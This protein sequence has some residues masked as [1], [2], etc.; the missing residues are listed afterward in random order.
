MCV[1]PALRRRVAAL[2]G[3]HGQF[4]ELEEEMHE[5]L[6]Q[7]EVEYAA[8]DWDDINYIPKE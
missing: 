8:R 1:P 4:E 2:E 6:R 5:R 3:L 7:V